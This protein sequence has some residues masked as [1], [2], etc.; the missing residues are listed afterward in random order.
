MHLPVDK[1]GM[2]INPMELNDIYDLL[3]NVGVLLQ[4]QDALTSCESVPWVH[5]CGVRRR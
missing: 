4:S 1:E 2:K 5:P 3:W